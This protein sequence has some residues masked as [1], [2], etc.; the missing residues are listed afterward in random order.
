MQGERGPYTLLTRRLVLATGYFDNPNLLEIPGEDLPHVRH[1]FDEAHLGY[2][3]DVVVIGGKNS[4]VETALLLYRAGAR[5][6]IVYRGAEFPRGVK[7][8]M[9]PDILNRI[10]AGS[11][12]A[13]FETQVVAIATDHITTE[14]ADGQRQTVPADRVY[15]LSGYH[16]D[17]K[18]FRRLGI[19]LD[20]SGKPRLDPDTIETNVPG[21]AMAGSIT[22]GPKIS[23]IFIENGRFDGEKIFG[24]LD[25]KLPGC[26]SSEG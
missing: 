15:A 1:Y 21:L 14:S 9:R 25:E 4:A 17:E 10:A 5:V 12:R 23:E 7:Y 16:A 18:L 6:T 13:L 26:D 20:E 2:D 24:K 3:L 22:A 11:I 8:W 19:E